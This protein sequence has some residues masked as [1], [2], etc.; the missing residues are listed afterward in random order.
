MRGGSRPAAL[1]VRRTRAS[2]R[3]NKGAHSSVLDVGTCSLS[4]KP[5]FIEPVGESQTSEG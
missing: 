3:L 4:M 2:T 1:G 5:R